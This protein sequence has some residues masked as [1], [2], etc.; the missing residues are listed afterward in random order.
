M[1]PSLF[2]TLTWAWIGVAVLA[3]LALQWVDAPYGRRSTDGW[4]PTVP[5]KVAWVV[6]EAVVLVA[7]LPGLVSG[8]PTGTVTWLLVAAFCVHYLNRAFVYPLRTR[9]SGKRMPVLIMAASIGFNTVN[10]LLIGYQLGHLSHYPPDWFT[11]PRFVVGA[12]LFVG[13]MAVNR[14]SDT[15]LIHLR[16]PGETGYRIPYGGAFRWV[17]SPNL[18]GELIEW[19]GFA[20]MSWCLPGLAFAVWTA[21]NVIPR[22]QANHRWYLEHFPDYPKDRAAIVPRLRHTRPTPLPDAAA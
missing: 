12:V 22:A 18:M 9:T 21:A 3:F 4:G 11:D 17:S 8:H 20:L 15:I 5:N 7:L 16:R 13:G 2:A 6:M 19:C 1:T 10:G 14:Q